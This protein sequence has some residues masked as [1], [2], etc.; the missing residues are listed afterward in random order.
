[1]LGTFALLG[2]MQLLGKSGCFCL[3]VLGMDKCMAVGKQFGL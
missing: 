1:M 3:G 2:K